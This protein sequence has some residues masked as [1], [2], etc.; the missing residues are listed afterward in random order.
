MPKLQSYMIFQE[1]ITDMLETLFTLS[2]FIIPAASLVWF[3][4]SLVMYMRTPKD[5][6]ELRKK[7]RLPFILSSIAFGVILFVVIAFMILMMLAVASM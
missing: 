1:R 3:I 4:I 7:R 6:A 2:L 5:N